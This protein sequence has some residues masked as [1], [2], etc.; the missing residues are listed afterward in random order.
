MD[1]KQNQ[2]AKK[3]SRFLR[4]FHIDPITLERIPPGETVM[5]GN[6][7]KLPN[8]SAYL[9]SRRPYSRSGLKYYI[10]SIQRRGEKP[11]NPITK[12][13]FYK[14]ELKRIDRSLVSNSSNSNNSNSSNRSLVSSSSNSNNSNNDNQRQYVDILVW[15]LNN[16]AGPFKTYNIIFPNQKNARAV[17]HELNKQIFQTSNYG[18][19][20]TFRL[21][22]LRNV[23][24][25]NIITALHNTGRYNKYNQK[26]M[27]WDT[28]GNKLK[29]LKF[30]QKERK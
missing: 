7:S 9:N 20:L 15:D 13:P 30:Y 11:N 16:E 2:A 27:K 24:V 8:T 26:S 5:I 23:K 4:G 21:P 6:R 22:T 14:S 10:E 25:R 18:K 1:R 12:Q 3:I 17:M 28:T 29:R 19:R